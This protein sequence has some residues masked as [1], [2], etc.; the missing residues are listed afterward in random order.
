[1]E[2]FA[3]RVVGGACHV[4]LMMLGNG[5]LTTR[6]TFLEPNDSG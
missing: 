1:M 2:R 6:W 3:S 5:I 4:M